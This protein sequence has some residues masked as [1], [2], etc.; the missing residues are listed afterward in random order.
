MK[1]NVVVAVPVA[2]RK[3]CLYKILGGGTEDTYFRLNM[4]LDTNPLIQTYILKIQTRAFVPMVANRSPK[5][6]INDYF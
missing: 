6:P 3:F 4:K 5:L 1:N 2:E